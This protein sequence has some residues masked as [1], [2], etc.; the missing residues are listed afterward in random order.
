MVDG[1]QVMLSAREIKN[2]DEIQLLNQAASMVDGVYHMIYEE[3]KPGV[4]E[5]EIVALSNKLLYEWGSDDVEAIK[6]FAGEDYRVSYYFD[7][8]DD[9]LIEKEPHVRHWDMYED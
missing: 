9:F 5:N 8:D 7:F 2:S 4:R 3:L 6:R 1:Q